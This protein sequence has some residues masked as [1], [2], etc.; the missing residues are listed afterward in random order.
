MG[1]SPK[2]NVIVQ[3]EIELIHYN[4]TMK[5]VKLYVMVTSVDLCFIF[6]SKFFIASLLHFSFD[7][8]RQKLKVEDILLPVLNYFLHTPSHVSV[9]NEN[10]SFLIKR[11][12]HSDN[13]RKIKRKTIVLL[14]ILVY[15]IS[16]YLLIFF[17]SAP[18]SHNLN[19]NSAYLL[20]LQIFFF[21]NLCKSSFEST[22]STPTI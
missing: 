5:N 20:F 1:I 9:R 11:R 3:L 22:H 2:V 8:S 19:K 13:P 10:C 17:P 7:L 6:L 12:H 14:F 15:F 18:W 21:L 4:I 16:F